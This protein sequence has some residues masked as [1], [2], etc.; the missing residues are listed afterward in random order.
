MAKRKTQKKRE[1][2]IHKDESVSQK[3]PSVRGRPL[4][5]QSSDELNQHID[6]FFDKCKSEKF[7]I[8]IAGLALHLGFSS[9]QTLYNYANRPEFLDSIKR[10]VLLVE[11]YYEARL[12]AKSPT[13]AI[14][15]LKNMG[16]DAEKHE[17]TK[18]IQV[19]DFSKFS[20]DQLLAMARELNESE[21]DESE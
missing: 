14:F 8:T 4:I 10:A 13:G 1:H 12:H 15:A 7:P 18:V 9:R 3:E 6:D 19:N 21:E 20:T 2:L 5:Y 16:W 17:S 11:M